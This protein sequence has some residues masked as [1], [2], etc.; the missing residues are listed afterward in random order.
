MKLKKDATLK[1]LKTLNKH[2][3]ESDYYKPKK[4]KKN[5]KLNLSL[6]FLKKEEKQSVVAS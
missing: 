6:F 1:I 3:E 4:K 2:G 5:Q